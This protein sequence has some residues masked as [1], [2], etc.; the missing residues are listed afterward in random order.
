MSC[1]PFCLVVL[2]SIVSSAKDN[3]M[4]WEE[5]LHA[6]YK[7]EWGQTCPRICKDKQWGFNYSCPG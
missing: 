4:P 3:Q 6:K 2:V 1:L 7:F 5:R